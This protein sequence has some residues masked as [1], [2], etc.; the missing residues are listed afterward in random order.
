M[1]T[2]KIISLV[3]TQT[4]LSLTSFS[5]SI[6]SL[7][8]NPSNPTTAD[9]IQILATCTFFSGNCDDHTQYYFINGN[10]IQ[11]GA[12][13]CLGVLSV[14]C[15]ATDTFNILPLP[16]GSYTCIFQADAGLGPSPCTPGIVAGPT[17]TLD[18]VVT[19]ATGQPETDL[20][21]SFSITPNP[22]SDHIKVHFHENQEPVKISISNNL[23]QVIC[24]EILSDSQNNFVKLD[25][26]LWPK[27]IYFVT[28][29]YEKAVLT[30]RFVKY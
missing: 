18:F 19:P 16:S 6:Q 3:F 30:R 17:D 14:I 24:S 11:S 23:G 2:F 27:G 22:A 4:L 8:I 26:N 13:H 21:N 15:N 25:I 7:T 1:K 28:V 12:L 20:E 5:Q 9:T 29:F 10:T